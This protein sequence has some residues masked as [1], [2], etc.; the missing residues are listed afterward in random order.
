MLH[1]GK[2]W[3]HLCRENIREFLRTIEKLH[4]EN[5]ENYVSLKKNRQSLLNSSSNTFG[6]FKQKTKQEKLKSVEMKIEHLK[7]TIQTTDEFLKMANYV[8]FHF[9]IEKYTNV[10]INL[11]KNLISFISSEK[12]KSISQ[13]IEY[14]HLINSSIKW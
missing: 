4:F 14:W 10:L 7:N 13:E 5:Q 6:F 12:I 1:K 11:R 9:E 8:I 3:L 2:K